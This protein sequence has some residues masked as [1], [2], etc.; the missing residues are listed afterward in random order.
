[1]ARRA[2]QRDRDLQWALRVCGYS[3][4][5]PEDVAF[6]RRA[7]SDQGGEATS[8]RKAGS[9]LAKDELRDLGI[10][11][12][13]IVSREFLEVLTE[14]GRKDPIRAAQSIASKF[15]GRRIA[16]DRVKRTMAAM[17]V[18]CRIKVLPNNMAA[19]PC[20]ACIDLA[21]TSIPIQQTPLGPLDECPHPDQCVL[22]WMVD[23]EPSEWSDTTGINAEEEERKPMGHSRRKGAVAILVVVGTILLILMASKALAEPYGFQGY[24]LGQTL[25][26]AERAKVAFEGG[27]VR[28]FCAGDAD[29]PSTLRALPETLAGGGKICRPYTYKY[30]GW[31]VADPV[32]SEGVSASTTLTFFADRLVRIELA[33]DRTAGALVEGALLAK[34]GTP[35]ENGAELV[36]NRLGATFEQRVVTWRDGGYG[37][38][39]RTPDLTIHRMTVTYTDEKGFSALREAERRAGATTLEM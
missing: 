27:G 28:L 11:S 22:H 13:V 29:A 34:Y 2:S 19:G 21:K 30:S 36:G 26:E 16:R 7:M 37:A 32:L 33:M 17:G 23:H 20:P 8:L 38:V 31:L 24:Q 39:L 18:D 9:V 12:N 5:R 1:M 4:G 3:L 10:R 14:K 15:L 6:A 25:G 35:A